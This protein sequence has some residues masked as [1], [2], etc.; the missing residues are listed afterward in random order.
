VAAARLNR[1]VD[2]RRHSTRGRLEAARWS[3]L[4]AV[5]PTM[6]RR[7][8]ACGWA[9]DARAGRVVAAARL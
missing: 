1:R 4:R 8:F 6:R 3:A 7:D 2:C 9:L 5:H